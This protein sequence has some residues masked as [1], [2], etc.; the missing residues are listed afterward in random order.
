MLTTAIQPGRI[1]PRVEAQWRVLPRH[2][3][4]DAF[5]LGLALC[6]VPVSIAI[7]ETLLAAALLFRLNSIAQHKAEF[8]LPRIFWVWLLWAA[9]E[10]A[11]WLHSP[12]IKAGL[13]ELRH[14]LLVAA[15]F[16]LLPA[17]GQPGYAV[18]IWRGIFLSSTLSS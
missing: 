18:T 1:L 14:L 4:A 13:G 8:R 16:L 6:A 7:A 11:A 3:K 2:W 12:D 10:I 17:L 9:L 5:T 15:L